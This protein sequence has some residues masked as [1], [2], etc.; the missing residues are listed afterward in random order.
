MPFPV[1]GSLATSVAGWSIAAG[2]TAS[3]V[4]GIFRVITLIGVGVAIF[5]GLDVLG[6]KVLDLF[7]QA[8]RVGGGIP[9]G[10]HPLAQVF[11]LLKVQEALS[12]LISGF[13]TRFT[14]RMSWILTKSATG[15]T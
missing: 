8:Q 9:G 5:E 14:Y 3:F 11:E 7:N 2:I 1:I 4:A 10:P 12:L 6:P 13:I 15:G